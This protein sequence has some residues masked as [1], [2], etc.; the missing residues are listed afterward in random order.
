LVHA[1]PLVIP[2]VIRCGLVTAHAKVA[3]QRVQPAALISPGRVRHPEEYAPVAAGA[4]PRFLRL[5]G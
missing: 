2:A 1:K 4:F 5:A 3:P